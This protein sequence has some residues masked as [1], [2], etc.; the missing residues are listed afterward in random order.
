MRF[1]IELIKP[2]PNTP[3]DYNT[4]IFKIAILHKIDQS[5]AEQFEL[6]FLTL[7]RA[8]VKKFI[9]D[10]DELKYIDSSGIGKL[11]NITKILRKQAGSISLARASQ[12]VMQIFK[13]VKLDTFIK[14]FHSIEEAVNY[15]KLA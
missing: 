6:F 3:A 1:D 2:N 13:L 7:I 8:G 12:E 4:L 14:I 5:M 10:L 9:I 11:I 15:L